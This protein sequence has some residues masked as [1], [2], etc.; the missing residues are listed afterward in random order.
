ML[1]LSIK[2][3]ISIIT[4]YKLNVSVESM[5]TKFRLVCFFLYSNH[6]KLGV[7]TF[8]TVFI[9]LLATF[10]SCNCWFL[11]LLLKSRFQF[12]FLQLIQIPFPL[13][14]FTYLLQISYILAWANEQITIHE[15]WSQLEFESRSSSSCNHGC[16]NFITINAE[17]IFFPFFHKQNMFGDLKEKHTEASVKL[18]LFKNKFLRFPKENSFVNVWKVSKTFLWCIALFFKVIEIFQRKVKA[19]KKE[20]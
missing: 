6:W 7:W 2:I 12:S 19:D 8:F 9:L 11:P 20:G 15:N 1:S 13:G 16:K 17:W 5:N 3:I 4:A 18:G 14:P 10:S